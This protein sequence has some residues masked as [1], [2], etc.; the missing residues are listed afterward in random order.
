VHNLGVIVVQSLLI[1]GLFWQRAR[2]RKAEAVLRE[3]EKRFRVMADTTPSQIWMCD[4]EGKVTYLN[5]R[6]L[7]FTGADRSGGYDDMWTSY[8]HPDDVKNVLDALSEA[9]KCRQ[10]FSSEYRLRRWD[11]VYR[12]M[13]DVAAPR[14]IGDGSFA[15]FIG[16][17]ID[18][19]DQKLALEALEKV[20]GQLI[21]AQEKERRRIARELHDDISQKLAMLSID[22]ERTKDGSEELPAVTKER[23]SEIQQRCSEVAHDVQALSHELHSSKLEHVGLVGAVRGLCRE[24]V[25]KHGVS[26]QFRDEN[27]PKHLTPEVS[28]CLFRVAQEALHNALRYS[29]VRQFAVEVTGTAEEIQLVVSDPGGGFDLEEAKRNGGLGLVSMQERVNY[30]WGHLSIESRPGEGT[31]IVASVPRPTEND[32][33]S[34]ETG[35]KRPASVSAE[36]A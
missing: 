4:R 2:K 16:S 22:L 32:C 20:S 25:Q 34:A 3:S 36:P 18:I 13:F 10:S 9:L 35:G 21:E 6:R 1:F 29:G 31:K 7:A 24:L 8:V 28:L 15:G 33:S 27:V 23:L 30:V 26:I 14:V 5:D 17:A 12:W 11:G 19:T